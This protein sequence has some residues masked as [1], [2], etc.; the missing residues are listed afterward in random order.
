MATAP[1]LAWTE[2]AWKAATPLEVALGAGV[3]LVG[4]G[5]AAKRVMATADR[6]PATG[7]P[8]S[9]RGQTGHLSD[10]FFVDVDA[11]ARNLRARGAKITGEDILGVFLSESGVRA[12]SRNALGFG[13]LNGMSEQNRRALGFTGGIDAWTRLSPEEQ[14]PFVR[15]YID[16]DIRAFAGGDYSALSGPSRLYLLN[17]TP[18][19]IRRPD[20]FVIFPRG[21]QGY[22]A[23]AGMDVNKDGAIDVADVGRF[24][25]KNVLASRTYFNELRGRL[26]SA[27]SGPIVAGIGLLSG[28]DADWR[29]SGQ[30]SR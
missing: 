28:G 6:L 13:G 15:R 9:G 27:M 11:L 17:F 20:S 24:L 7:T 4:A 5:W 22:N 23:N 25:S 12:T 1:W 21:T 18:A 10:P 8:T 3:L 29:T 30:A 16:A 19:H 2:R 14:L 26:A